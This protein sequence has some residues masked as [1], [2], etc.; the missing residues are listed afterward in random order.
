MTMSWRVRAPSLPKIHTPLRTIVNEAL[1]NGLEQV[2][3]PAI[4]RSYRTETHIVECLQ[5]HDLDNIQES[6][7]WIEGEDFG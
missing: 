5:G 7:T 3:K 2:E 1:H 6:Q 4:Q